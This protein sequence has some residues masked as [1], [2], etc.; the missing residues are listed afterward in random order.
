MASGLCVAAAADPCLEGVILDGVNGLLAGTSDDSVR[1][2]LVRAF[3]PDG[4]RARANAV[5]GAARYST[6]A[7]AEAIEQSYLSALGPDTGTRKFSL[8]Y[9][10]KKLARKVYR[11]T[12][13]LI[14]PVKRLYRHD[15]R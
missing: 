6:A 8:G 14:R 12:G 15:K 1:D 2:T 13:K 5:Q 4:E 9:S 10:G 3:G 7:F 11:G